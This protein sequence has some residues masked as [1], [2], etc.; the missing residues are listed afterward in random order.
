M[1]QALAL[2]I[3]AAVLIGITTYEARSQSTDDKKVKLCHV[4]GNGKAHVIDISVN[5]KD[6]HLAHGD[7]LTVPPGAKSGDPCTIT[8]PPPPV[9]DGVLK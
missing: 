1:K 5:A 9:S 4:T 7:G 6:T 8:P 2:A 3:G